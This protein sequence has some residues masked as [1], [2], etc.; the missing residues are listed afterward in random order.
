MNDQDKS[1]ELLLIELQELRQSKRELTTLMDNLQGMV[2]SCLFDEN[3]TM[4][5]VSEGSLALTGYHPNEFIDNASVAY[6]D[7]IDPDD[8]EM[9]MNTIQKAIVNK[10]P[11]TIEYRLVDKN[12][13]VKL[14]WEKGRGIY[15]SDWKVH[16]L[17]GLITDIT[18][19]RKSDEKFKALE[20]QSRAWLENSP[21]CTK[22][23][24]LN[25]NLQFMSSTG[26]KGL[27]IDNITPYYGKPYP[28]HFYP[29]SFKTKM[30][31]NMIKAKETGEVITQEAPVV[32][33]NGNEVWYHSTIVPVKNDSG[34]T[35]Y[36]IIV[37]LD[38]TERKLAEKELRESEEKYRVL[39]NTFLWG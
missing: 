24:D 30:T 27:K 4:K 1:K 25:F 19:R 16:H 3:R 7:I 34:K 39:F 18:D 6:V 26:V 29:E 38:T 12:G 31:G 15:T 8:R 9:V 14:V 32:D 2:Y 28:F 22:I 35:E 20:Q 13:N 23:V 10:E 33:I 17:E 36:L 5:F 21:V 37:S 11:F